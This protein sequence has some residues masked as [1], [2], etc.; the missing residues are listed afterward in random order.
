MNWFKRITPGL[1]KIF[2]IKPADKKDLWLKCESC[3]AMIF[4]K[5]ASDNLFVCTECDYH[6][7]ISAKER[8]RQ[9]LDEGTIKYL[10]NPETPLDPLKFKDQ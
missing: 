7:K 1:K 8:F 5:D 2:T 10:D 9:L 3:E 4:H 6:M